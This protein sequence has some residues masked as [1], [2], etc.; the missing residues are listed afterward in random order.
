M[1]CKGGHMD[2]GNG[3][4]NVGGIDEIFAN[5]TKNQPVVDKK[6]EDKIAELKEAGALLW[7]YKEK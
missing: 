3:R 1:E 6:I 7:G 4:F 2:A 5:Q